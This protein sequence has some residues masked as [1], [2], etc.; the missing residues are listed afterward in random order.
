M[1]SFPNCKINLG[2][3]ILRRREDG[4]HDLETIFYPLPVTDALEIIRNPDPDNEVVYSSSGLNIDGKEENNL[5]IKAW[6]LLKKDHPALPSIKLHLHKAIPMGAGLGGG[7]SDGAFTLKMLNE[8]FELGLAT[9]QLM[10]YAA[11]LGSDGPFFIP[12]QPSFA[13]GRGELL[14]TINID[15]SH[16]HIV[17]VNPGIHVNTGW[18]FSQLNPALPQKSIRDI[19]QQPIISWKDELVNDFERPVMKE[20][21]AIQKIRDE[22]YKM[23]ALF[24]SMTG[25]GSSV[26][27]IFEEEPNC[28]SFAADHYFIRIIRPLSR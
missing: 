19:I 21:P 10:H 26:F 20:Y 14:E 8:K 13:S 3:H 24:A 4:F 17:L 7:S 12:D 15:L 11:E 22:L 1:L 25:S 28:S 5:C 9:E 16:Y 18:A 2:L 23:G 6:K 27:G